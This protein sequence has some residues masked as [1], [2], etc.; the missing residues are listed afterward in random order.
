ML[1]VRLHP[2]LYRGKIDRKQIAGSLGAAFGVV[3]GT[4][5]FAGTSINRSTEDM[6]KETEQLEEE[7]KIQR[8]NNT[9]KLIDRL[10]EQQKE[11]GV[12]RRQDKGAASTAEKLL[13]LYTPN[14]DGE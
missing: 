4:A 7:H 1:Q 8:M 5:T 14:H 10:R 6:R 12:T 13:Y 2:I 11:G 9:Q 3:G